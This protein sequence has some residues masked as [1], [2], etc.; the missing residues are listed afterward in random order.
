[1]RVFVLLQEEA[2]G[3]LLFF[4]LLWGILLLNGFQADKRFFT[5]LKKEF[6]WE[7]VGAE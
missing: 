6:S 2:K 3:T 1:M 7:E 5:L 4:Y